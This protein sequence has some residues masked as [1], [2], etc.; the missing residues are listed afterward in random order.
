MPIP[1]DGSNGESLAHGTRRPR[2][3]SDIL[4]PPP[5][6][7]CRYL[8]FY[9]GRRSLD[10]ARQVSRW[11]RACGPAGRFKRSVATQV[12]KNSGRWDDEEVSPVIRQ[13]CWQWAYELS[14][15]D[16]KEY[17]PDGG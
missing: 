4:S 1:G 13:V 2:S 17:L 15:R 7:A 5:L 16:Y 11:Q 9:L 8:R 3:D 6:N 12:A 14:E 10:D